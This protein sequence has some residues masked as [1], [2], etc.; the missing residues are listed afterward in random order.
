MDAHQVTAYGILVVDHV[1]TD[2]H[3]D[4]T[5]M[6]IALFD[7]PLT[8]QP[9]SPPPTAIAVSSPFPTPRHRRPLK[10]LTIEPHGKPPWFENT[11]QKFV[12]SPHWHLGEAQRQSTGY[13]GISEKPLDTRIVFPTVRTASERLG[14]LKVAGY[15]IIPFIK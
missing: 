14:D 5:M 9:S 2:S 7:G 11:N 8:P 15:R 13:R 12:Q 3:P 10:P 4:T 6:D 1:T